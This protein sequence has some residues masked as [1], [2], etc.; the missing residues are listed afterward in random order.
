MMT[1]KMEMEILGRLPDLNQC[2]QAANAWRGGFNSLKK[3][4]QAEIRWQIMSR[5]KF[6][7]FD[8]L[9]HITYKWHEP[10]K[11]RDKDNICFAKKFINDALVNLGILQ[12]DGWDNIDSFT[13]VFLIDSKRP[14]VEIE[15]KEIQN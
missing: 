10:N 7:S 11:K 3:N 14:R 15:I 1:K 13:D 9:V 4:A 8:N 5:Y 6:V 12:D 2:I